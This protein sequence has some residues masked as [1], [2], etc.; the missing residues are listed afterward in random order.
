[1][2]KEDE[3]GARER[4]G[5]WQR[6]EAPPSQASHGGSRGHGGAGVTGPRRGGVW[7]GAA[8]EEEGPRK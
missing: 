4:Q 6:L 1:M 3:E 2:D 8:H 5:E 7:G